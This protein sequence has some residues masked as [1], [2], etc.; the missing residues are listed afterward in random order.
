M[1]NFAPLLVAQGEM[2]VLYAIGNIRIYIY[3]YIYMYVCMF[4]AVNPTA[5]SPVRVGW[6]GWV[7][8]VWFGVGL[9]LAG[10]WV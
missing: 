10:W 2:G 6:G 4:Q 1:P 9:G 5:P 8:G 3:I 7:A